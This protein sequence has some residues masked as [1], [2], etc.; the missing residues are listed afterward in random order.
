MAETDNSRDPQTAGGRPK[1]QA[2]PYAR[3][4]RKQSAP[5]WVR[6]LKTMAITIVTLALLGILLLA[7][8]CGSF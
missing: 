3:V 7:V 1:R 5:V 2:L 4:Q 6:I 8:F